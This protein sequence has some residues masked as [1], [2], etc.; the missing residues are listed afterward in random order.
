MTGLAVVT[1]VGRV[2]P[3]IHGA[4]RRI[5]GLATHLCGE[6]FNVSILTSSTGDRSVQSTVDGV[7]IIETPPVIS[8]RSCFRRD[9]GRRRAALE[10]STFYV[11]PHHLALLAKMVSSGDLHLIQFEFPYVLP[12]VVPFKLLGL[13]LILD[14]HGVE[15][16]FV[17]ELASSR[18]VRP[19]RAD[20]LRTYIAESL[21]I[22]MAS[23]VLCCSDHDVARMS[24]I[25]GGRDQKYLVVENGADESFFE[26]V[27]PHAFARPT[28]L[29]VGSFDHAPNRY[30]ISWILREIAPRVKRAAPEVEFA[31]IGSA[32][33]TQPPRLDNAV[34]FTN[35]SDIRPFIRGASVA[36]STVFH[37]SGTRL[38]TLEYLACGAPVVS[39]TR[40][41]TGYD[42]RSGID[43]L[44]ADDRDDVAHAIVQLL[45]SPARAKDMGAHGQR[46]VHEKYTWEAIVKKSRHAYDELLTR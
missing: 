7:R 29:Y 9:S 20:L 34:V 19:G 11:N 33:M 3:P 18:G 46:T 28:V 14:Q 32:S 45:R 38:K 8:L 17:C 2:Y 31:F 42:L 22:R 15:L 6:G 30:A 25:Y 26:P 37:G 40:G 21:A 16:D 23:L 13:P 43:L 1:N 39:T 27:K 41:V 36:L 4:A 5:W 12:D 35:I 24:A 44:V 10:F